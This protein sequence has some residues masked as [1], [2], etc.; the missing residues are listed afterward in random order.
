VAGAYVHGFGQ[1][2]SSRA[3]G[4]G[5]F[6]NA[7]YNATID[8][9]LGEI[10]YYFMQNQGRIVPKVAFEY[11]RSSTD[12][13][14][15]RG[16][17]FFL[18]TASGATAE[19]ARALIGAEVGHYWIINRSVFDLSAYAKFVDNFYQNFSAVTVSIPGFQSVSVTGIGESRY[20]ADIGAAASL[21]LTNRLRIYARYDGKLRSSFQSH[22]G[23][24]GL[25]VK[26]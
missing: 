3:T 24:A 10:D 11:V 22:Q 23:L 9:V 21:S 17:A 18:V 12:G 16:Q 8:G 19:R 1:I 20:G 4:G 2:A 6:A 5:F 15:E 25:E 14:T 26:W 13:F 7:N